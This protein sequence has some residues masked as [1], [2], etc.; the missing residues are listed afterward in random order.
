MFILRH[1]HPSSCKLRS[2]FVINSA[3]FFTGARHFSASQR[4]TL[5]D[6]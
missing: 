3:I 6:S 1:V 2:F 4:K 5:S